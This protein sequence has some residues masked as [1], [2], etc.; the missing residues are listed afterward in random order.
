MD[1][2]DD[3]NFLIYYVSLE[4]SQTK[5]LSK[6][7]SLYL[8]ETYHIIVPYQKLM[9]WSEPLDDWTYGYIQKARVW[10][11]SI[12][13]KLIIYDKTLNR[14]SF[15]HTVMELY[16]E[17]GQWVESEDGRRKIYIPD[18][19]DL[20]ILTVIDH[21]G[22]VQPKS[23][24]TKKD[25]IDAISSYAVTLREKCGASF[26]VLQQENRNSSNMDRRKMEMTECSPDDLEASSGPYHDCEVCI[27]VYHPL[28]HKLKTCHDYPIICNE[29]I[30]G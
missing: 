1:H 7:L 19:P 8:W 16:N 21:I 24:A 14:D 18:N 27:G 26:L 15:Y 11:E 17:R 9:S 10:L 23:G 28:K 6:L 29:E 2:K 20:L 22:L 12:N 13:K 3:D 30:D 4:M 25:E 5:L